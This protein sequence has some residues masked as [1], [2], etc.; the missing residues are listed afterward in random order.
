MCIYTMN[1]SRYIYFK[2]IIL[3]QEK[4]LTFGI[5]FQIYRSAGVIRLIKDCT[6][7]RLM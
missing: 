6:D 2:T 5:S 4:Y 1:M 7:F 3:N